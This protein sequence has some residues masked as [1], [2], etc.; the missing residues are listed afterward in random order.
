MN[1]L[2][3]LQWLRSGLQ[4]RLARWVYALFQQ[5]QE[6]AV[7]AMFRRDALLAPTARILSEACIRNLHGDPCRIQIG[8]HTFVRG[9][10]LVFAHDGELSIGD[11]CYIGDYTRIWSS[12]KIVIGNRVL[13]SHGV[14][15]HDTN[16]HP[17][18]A[19]A[20]HAH[21]LHIIQFGH[22]RSDIDIKA[23]PIIIGDD[24]WIGFGATILKGV[25][26]GQGAIVAAGSVVTRDVAPF[27]VVAGNPAKEIQIYDHKT[28]AA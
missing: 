21:F 15:I 26:I 25:T 19:A 18:N 10:V 14:N 11:Y 16:S 28:D 4:R 3:P 24:V 22:P 2:K 5:G 9:E 8:E 23:A 7:T 20:R 1:I 12:A 17:L 6:L 27:A 13:I